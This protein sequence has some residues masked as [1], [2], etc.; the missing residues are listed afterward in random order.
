[1]CGRRGVA[2]AHASAPEGCTWYWSAAL[3]IG[4]HY[5]CPLPTW[6]ARE[7]HWV[8]RSGA[9]GLGRWHDERRIVAD[10]YRA[11]VGAVPTRIVAVWLI[12]VSIFGPSPRRRRLRD[13]DRECVV[14]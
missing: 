6:A 2:T 8:V 11:A 9:D 5:A 7:T 10:D 4:T 14:V 3:P 1:V 12:A 13:G